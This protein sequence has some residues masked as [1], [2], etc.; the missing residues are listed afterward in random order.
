MKFTKMQGIGNDYVY[1]NCFEEAVEDP[2]QLSIKLS[3]RHFGIGSDGLI[4]ICPS[5]VADCRMRMFNADGSESSM[6]GNG[7]RCVGKY[8]FD[9]HLV[10]KTEFDVETGAGIKHLKVTEEN[11]KAILLT[12]DMG[13]PEVTSQIPEPICVDGTD[14]EFIGISMGNPHAVYYMD[15]IDS[16]DLESI[17]PGFENHERFPERTNSEFIEVISP[18]HIRMRVWERGSGETWACGTGACAS[19]VASALCGRTGNTVLVSLK[20]G[21]LT[22]HWDREGSGHVF[23]TG[24]AVEVFEGEFDINNF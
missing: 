2:A 3:D 4:L 22:I 14:Y 19:A 7:I 6:C 5:R 24:P 12:V 11:G 8:V 10:D 15:D 21:N 17:G 9:H 16:L 1:I 23:M 20:G 18:E 13:I